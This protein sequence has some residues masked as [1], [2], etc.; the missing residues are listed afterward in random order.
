MRR[1]WYLICGSGAT[2]VAGSAFNIKTGS[3]SNVEEPTKSGMKKSV[4]I[5]GAGL[6]GLGTAL[7]L[8]DRGHKVT[9]IE[10]SHQVADR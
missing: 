10:R 8:S 9:V 3:T 6:M 5:V 4:V 7:H 2:I 1:I